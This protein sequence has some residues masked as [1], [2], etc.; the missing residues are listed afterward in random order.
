VSEEVGAQLEAQGIRRGRYVLEPVGQIQKFIATRL[1]DASRD[2]PTFPLMVDLV[3]DPLLELRARYNGVNSARVSVNDLVI[4]A[5]AL[6]LVKVPAVNSSFTAQGFVR[7][8]HADIAVAVG[9]K[10][11]LITPII[12]A[13]E[14]KNVAQI[15]MDARDL[16]DRARARRLK[17]DEYTGGTFAVSNLG[18]FGIKS[19]GSIIN[20]P[21]AAILSVGAATPAVVAVSG[22]MRIA[23]SMSVTLTCDHRVIDGVIGATWLKAFRDLIE[24]PQLLFD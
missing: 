17:P 2:T 22:D 10:S 7:H 18:M 1:T 8:L 20:P 13:A 21:H 23:T 3:I 15:S 24:V 5:A 6:A 14:E 19:F 9:T 11:G 4:R 12:W 16:A